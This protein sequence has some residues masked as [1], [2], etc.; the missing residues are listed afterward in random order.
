MM[1]Q[2]SG[3]SMSHASKYRHTKGQDIVQALVEVLDH[4]SWDKV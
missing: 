3:T 4:L 1:L 2:Q